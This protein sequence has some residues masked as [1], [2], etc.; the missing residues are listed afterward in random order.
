MKDY[1]NISFCLFLFTFQL[2]FVACNDEIIHVDGEIAGKKYFPLETG[3][4]W[5]YEYDS[6]IFERFSGRILQRT[7]WIREEISGILDDGRFRIERSFKKNQ[8]DPWVVSEIWSAR[9]EEQ[10]AIRTEQNLPFIKLVFPPFNNVQW[11]GNA[12]FRDDIRILVAGEQLQPYLMWQYRITDTEGVFDWPHGRLQ[13]VITVQQADLVSLIDRRYSYERFAPGVGM[14]EKFK[15]ILDCQCL[16]VPVT[17]PWE[18]KAEKGFIL[19]QKLI[20]YY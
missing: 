16:G 13:D 18:E 6:I 5:I 2:I 10:R 8:N 11:D 4:V 9:I 7:G 12:L 19:S 14:V 20:D 17:V 15:M 1:L 3:R